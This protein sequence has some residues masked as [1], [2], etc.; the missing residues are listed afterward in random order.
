VTVEDEVPWEG[1]YTHASYE[2]GAK[3][4]ELR[5]A[6]PYDEVVALDAIMTHLAT[7]LWDHCFSQSE[8]KAAFEQ[9][10]TLLEP[11]CAGQ[12]RRG[13]RNRPPNSN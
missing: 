2:F 13:D 10:V 12:E 9:A 3:C 1:R 11:Y 7:E 8:I 4:A 5:D 6:N